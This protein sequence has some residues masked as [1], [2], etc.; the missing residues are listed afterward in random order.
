MS[1]LQIGGLVIC[2]IGIGM[3]NV[4]YLKIFLVFKSKMKPP[5]YNAFGVKYDEQMIAIYDIVI[6]ELLLVLQEREKRLKMLLH[7]IE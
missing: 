4:M 2:L 6:L 5:K 7:T 1:K 3:M